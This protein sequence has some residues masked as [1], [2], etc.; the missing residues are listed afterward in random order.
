M[1][2]AVVTHGT[3]QHGITGQAG[4]DCFLRQRRAFTCDGDAT[5]ECIGK[6]ELVA[7]GFGH[8]VEHL[9]R[10]RGD[11]GADAVA[12]EQCDVKLHAVLSYGG[13]RKSRS[14]RFATG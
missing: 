14:L 8:G 10:F 6:G 5:D 9:D 4:V 3:E 11:L 2:E 12:G 1:V 13:G 7:A